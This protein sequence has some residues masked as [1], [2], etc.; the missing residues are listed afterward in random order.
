MNEDKD[1]KV[2]NLTTHK[3]TNSSTF[4]IEGEDIMIK[5]KDNLRCY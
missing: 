1:N 4:V 5:P 3:L 2:V